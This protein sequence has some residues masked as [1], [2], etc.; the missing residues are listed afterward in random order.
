MT[1]IQFA[2]I[3][4]YVAKNMVIEDCDKKKKKKWCPADLFNTLQGQE[5]VFVGNLKFLPV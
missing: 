5:A 4:R 3:T 2:S 1:A